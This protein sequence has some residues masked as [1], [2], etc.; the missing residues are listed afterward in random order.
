MRYLSWI[1]IVL[2]FGAAGY[3][4]AVWWQDRDASESADVPAT[5]EQSPQ[6][7]NELDTT[8][9]GG[10]AAG[11]SAVSEGDERPSFTLPD[12][13]GEERSIDEWDGD[14]LVVNFWATWCP[15]CREETPMFVELQDEYG[16]EGL[17]FIGV[18]IDDQTSVEQFV[19]EFFVQ[20]PILI[21]QEEAMEI[22]REWGNRVGA[23]PYTVVVDRD[24]TI[25]Y[26]H[27]GEFME[28]DFEKEVRPL[29]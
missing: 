15:P 3:G 19:D 18:A 14:V 27:R 6:G 7:G 21:G 13:D 20:Y 1:L 9:D 25:A 22:G 2:V 8:G 5:A 29:L 11:D 10:A 23:L 17:Q 16:D 4:A 24:G 26:T 12:L 28:E